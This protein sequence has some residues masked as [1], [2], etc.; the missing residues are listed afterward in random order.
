MDKNQ[1]NIFL[2]D[3]PRARMGED[4]IKAYSK[5]IDD[6][7][8]DQ[9]K[10]LSSEERL[11][12]LSDLYDIRIPLD[13]QRK[14]EF[15]FNQILMQSL[16]KRK[17][18]YNS[19][20]LL[21]NDSDFLIPGKAYSNDADGVGSGIALLGNG[22]CGKTTSVGIMLSNYQQVIDRKT[23]LGT[24]KQIL[25]LFV[26]CP[27]NGDFKSLLLS[28][29]AAMDDAMETGTFCYDTVA[30]EQRHSIEAMTDRICRFIQL[31]AVGVLI[32]DEIQELDYHKNKKS[33]LDNLLTIT[34][35]TK[36]GLFVIGTEKAYLQFA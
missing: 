4:L 29:A 33:T 2:S 22:G 5:G 3:I 21:I 36:V 28:I 32:I 25:Y 17:F 6:F 34:N 23:E 13:Y 8:Y 19:T 14:L 9:I 31:F 26:T 10:Q 1:D 16:K 35:R 18:I 30:H 11:Y 20:T 27:P 24:F 7:D 15:R 12:M